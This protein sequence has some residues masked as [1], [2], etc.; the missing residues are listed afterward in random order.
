MLISIESKIAEE[1]IAGS[2]RAGS[3]IFG[4]QKPPKRAV[5]TVYTSVYTCI[6]RKNSYIRV[7]KADT[8]AGSVKW[9]EYTRYTVRYT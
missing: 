3:R 7:W 1:Q 9:T 4:S 2:T 8:G 6:H 5:Y